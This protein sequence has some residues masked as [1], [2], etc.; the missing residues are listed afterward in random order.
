MIGSLFEQ[1]CIIKRHPELTLNIR[2]FQY[3]TR[4]LSDVVVLDVE[5]NVTILPKFLKNEILEDFV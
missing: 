4:M 3:N 2:M 1:L 5:I